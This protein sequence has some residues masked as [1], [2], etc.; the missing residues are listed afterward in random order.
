M[1][2]ALDVQFTIAIE[3]HRAGAIL[4]STYCIVNLYCRCCY[5]L[6]SFLLVDYIIILIILTVVVSRPNVS[7]S[8]GSGGSIQAVIRLKQ[9]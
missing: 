3:S 6:V 2:S 4:C 1:I 9:C 5:C 7:M 8:G